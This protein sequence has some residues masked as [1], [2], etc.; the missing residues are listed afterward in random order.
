MK[1][2]VLAMIPKDTYFVGRRIFREVKGEWLYP[3]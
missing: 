3:L 2:K 1:H